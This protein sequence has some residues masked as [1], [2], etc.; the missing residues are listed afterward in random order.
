MALIAY[1]LLMLNE[2]S[3]ATVVN[4]RGMLL[5]KV[6]RLVQLPQPAPTSAPPSNENV[7]VLWD[8]VGCAPP[9]RSEKFRPKNIT[10]RTGRVNGPRVTVTLAVMVS[11][12]SRTRGLNPPRASSP[13]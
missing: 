4:D 13:V 6:I 10:S 7:P 5:W 3:P 1:G 11:P 12:S 2:P 8:V 9:R